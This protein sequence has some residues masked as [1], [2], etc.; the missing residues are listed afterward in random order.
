M[1]ESNVHISVNKRIVEINGVKL[2]IDLRTAKRIDEYKIGDSIKVL[3]KSYGEKWDS[4]FGMI[5]AFDEFKTRPTMIIAYL[6]SAGSWENPL[7]F[8]YLN[9][10]SKDVE[11]CHHDAADIGVERSDILTAFDREI[12]KKEQELKEIARKRDYFERMFGRYFEKH[13]EKERA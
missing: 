7:S 5:V 9:S 2:E 13:D 1:S 10:D 4:H 12:S 6:K 8:V 11:I 3:I